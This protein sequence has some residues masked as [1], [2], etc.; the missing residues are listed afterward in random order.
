M[1]KRNGEERGKE[2]GR[3]GDVNVFVFRST[4]NS[5]LASH[6]VSK[7]AV[8]PPSSTVSPTPLVTCLDFH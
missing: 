3:M 8:V 1:E 7:I 2:R 6:M 5:Y 4:Y